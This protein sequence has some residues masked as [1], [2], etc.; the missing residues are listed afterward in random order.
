MPLLELVPSPSTTPAEL[1][2]AQSYFSALSSGHRP[3]PIH[4]ESA[5]FV[6]NRLSFILFREACHLVNQG[7]ASVEEIDEIVRASLGPRW[8]VGGPFRM[9]GFGGG[10]RGMEGF[11]DNIGEAIDGVWKDAGTI[12]MDRDVND[13]EAWQR[14]VIDQTDQAYGVLGPEEIRQRD[15]GLRAVVKVQEELTRKPGERQES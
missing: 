2:F 6:A 12:T 13:P 15:K 7:V 9:Y 10:K 3:I 8:A 5:G 11:L 14:K 4:K 1:T